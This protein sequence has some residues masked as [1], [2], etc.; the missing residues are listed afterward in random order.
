VGAGLDA[1]EWEA[2]LHVGAGDLR[3]AEETMMATLKAGLTTASLAS[4]YQAGSEDEGRRRFDA[5]LT[6]ASVMQAPLLRI[7]AC[8][9]VG[10]PED[11]SSELRRLGDKSAQRGITLCI[12]FGRKTFLDRYER[13]KSLLDAVGHDFVKLAWE[14]LPGA[15]KAEAT[16]ALAELGRLAGLVVARCAA[17]DGSA[18]PIAGEEDAWRERL[19]AFK[20]VE[21]DPKMGSFVFLGAKRVEGSAGDESL[22]RDSSSLR[23]IVEEIEPRRRR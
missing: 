13:A 19:R 3:A 12:S 4:I 20:L 23:A 11:F 7:Y 21:K 6:T 5:L 17:K 8:A 10:K 14:D 16:A 22:S 18:L 15:R 9:E 1:I 2:N